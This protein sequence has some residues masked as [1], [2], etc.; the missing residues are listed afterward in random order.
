MRTQPHDHLKLAAQ[1]NGWSIDEGSCRF[2]LK[3]YGV[4]R[5]RD[6]SPTR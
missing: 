5:S 3:M 1:P 2:G 6:L 4:V